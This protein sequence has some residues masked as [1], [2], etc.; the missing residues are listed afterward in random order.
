MDRQYRFNEGF[1]AGCDERIAVGKDND[2]IALVWHD[3]DFRICTCFA[4]AV[5]VDAVLQA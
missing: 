1:R 3:V 2:D 4:A 5:A